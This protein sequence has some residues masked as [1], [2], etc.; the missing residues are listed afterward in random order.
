MDGPALRYAHLLRMT[1][2]VGLTEHCDHTRPRWQLGYCVDDVARAV[3]VVV[4]DPSPDPDVAELGARCL[5]FLLEAVSRDGRIH[6]RRALQGGWTDSPGIGD[7]WGR[8]VWA[9]GTVSG[10]GPDPTGRVLRAFDRAA[11]CR[12][13]HLRAM[14]YAGL[15]AA[16]VLARYPDHRLARG[17]L[18]DSARVA[19]P[20]ESPNALDPR[21]PWPEPRLRYA[22]GV[23]PEV[24]LAAAVALG[25]MTCRDRGLALLDW[26]LTTET[27]QEKSG[28]RLSVTPVA[29]WALGEPRPGY[30]QQPIEVA[31]LAEA[32]AR[33]WML[34]G[35]VRWREAV[36]MAEDWFDG[37]ND[38]GV[39]LADAVSGGC[40]DGLTEDGRNENQ[41]AESTLALVAVRQLAQ[42]VGRAGWARSASE[43]DGAAT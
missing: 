14:A 30:D 20:L 27:V 12:S 16:E 29:G 22:N 35:D 6:N 41:G 34:T 31:A 37:R 32:S 43:I 38:Q 10:R 13:S 23:V 24:L 15:G 8:A 40:C 5:E 7:W 11:Q 18:Q 28:S 36:L 25:D 19:D 33:A 3:I 17:L 9:L 42:L 39:A 26:L 21:W 4:R 2:S 1:D